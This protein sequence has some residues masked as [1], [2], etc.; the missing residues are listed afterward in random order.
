M[1]VYYMIEKYIL[2]GDKLP[3]LPTPHD[4]E[5]VEIECKDDYLIFKFCDEINLYDSISYVHPNANSLVIKYHLAQPEVYVYKWK[6]RIFGK[7]YEF[8]DNKKLISK[9]KHLEYLYQYVSY[10]QL[11]IKLWS[12]TEIIVEFECDYVEYEWL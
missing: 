6:N 12:M 3:T 1:E 7:G 8:V 10:S 11:I 2:T 4:C 5:I 9:H